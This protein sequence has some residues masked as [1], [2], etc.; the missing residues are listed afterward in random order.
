MTAVHSSVASDFVS[1]FKKEA[2]TKQ[3]KRKS[4][5][6][7]PMKNYSLGGLHNKKAVNEK[8]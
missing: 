2:A 3:L 1:I 7:D 8:T 5:P 4:D 6:A